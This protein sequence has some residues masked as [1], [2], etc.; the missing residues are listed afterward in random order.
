MACNQFWLLPHP[1]PGQHLQAALLMRYSEFSQWVDCIRSFCVYL[2]EIWSKEVPF[3]K[4]LDFSN[5]WSCYTRIRTRTLIKLVFCCAGSLGQV[6]DCI[7]IQRHPVCSLWPIPDFICL[8]CP[9][10][11]LIFGT[12][13]LC[14]ELLVGFNARTITHDIFHDV[15]RLCRLTMLRP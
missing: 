14:C 5:I 6:R 13:R 15:C 3:L 12:N 7:L 10:I 9:R 8:D 2:L 4:F 11:L 1:L